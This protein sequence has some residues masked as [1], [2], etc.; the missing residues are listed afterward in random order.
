MLIKRSLRGCNIRNIILTR[1][2][3]IL[4]EVFY[5]L[6]TSLIKSKHMRE[7][8]F[9]FGEL[10]HSGFICNLWEFIFEFYYNFCAI[11]YPKYEKLFK[12][13]F[14]D[15]EGEYKNLLNIIIILFES[16]KNFDVF[17]NLNLENVCIN[18]SPDA[19]LLNWCK[20]MHTNSC[21]RLSVIKRFVFSLNGKCYQNILSELKLIKGSTENELELINKFKEIYLLIIR[22][23][24]KYHK[25]CMVEE[26]SDITNNAVLGNHLSDIPYNNKLH[27]LIALIHYLYRDE[28]EINKEDLE[29]DYINTKLYTDI[30]DYLMRIN[31]LDCRP[32]DVLYKKALYPINYNIGCFKLARFAINYEELKNIYLNKWEFYSYFSLI[33]RKRFDK[34]NIK[35]N[36]NTEE[37]IFNNDEEHELFYNE[38]YYETDELSKNMQNYSIGGIKNITPQDWL[39]LNNIPRILKM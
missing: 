19:S 37:I 38:F 7:V 26:Y 2:H 32:R 8:I 28:G 24:I 34:Y 12:K 33:W 30:N 25:T 21:L 20:K 35:I 10:Y 36:Y 31:T 17:T 23:F 1:Y 18:I 27:I 9:W 29:Y 13:Y 11:T 16:E 15:K 5:T 6:Q 3:Y 4:D 22:Y 14:N 39:D